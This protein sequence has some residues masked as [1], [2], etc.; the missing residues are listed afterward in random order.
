MRGA[1]TARVTRRESI[2]SGSVAASTPPQGPAIG[3][4][5]A[6]E[7]YGWLDEKLAVAWD[8]LAYCSG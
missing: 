2:H 3:E 6:P 8:A 7:R 1:L 5:T 4:D